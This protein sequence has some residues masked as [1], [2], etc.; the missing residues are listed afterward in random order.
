MK[1]KKNPH[2]TQGTC[3]TSE[4][5]L[6]LNFHPVFPLHRHTHLPQD[7]RMPYKDEKVN[8][9]RKLDRAPV[10][11]RKTQ[12]RASVQLSASSL[13][14]DV[15]QNPGSRQASSLPGQTC[16]T[17]YWPRSMPSPKPTEQPAPQ[18]PALLDTI[19]SSS[20]H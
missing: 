6:Q 1:T 10:L 4:S 15:R 14:P 13:C 2:A 3:M 17:L 19:S 20:S 12:T 7:G 8:K 16:S 5:K 11:P 18:S 9:P